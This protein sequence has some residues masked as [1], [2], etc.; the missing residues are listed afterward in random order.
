MLRSNQDSLFK[1]ATSKLPISQQKTK[2]QATR[3]VFW[4]FVVL[5]VSACVHQNSLSS[6]EVENAL[7]L[8]S[9]DQGAVMNAGVSDAEWLKRTNATELSRDRVEAEMVTGKHEKSEE[10]AR[11]LLARN[12]ASKEGLEAL[13]TSLYLQGRH[14][15][16]AY[17]AKLL[18][19]KY[20]NNTVALNISGLTLMKRG[21]DPQDLRQAKNLFESAFSDDIKEIAAGLNLGHLLLETGNSK[22][23]VSIFEQTASRCNDCLQAILGA[24]IAARRA[25]DFSTSK[26]YLDRAIQSKSPVAYY[27]LALWHIQSSNDLKSAREALG[28]VRFYAQ[29]PSSLIR[30]KADSFF[31]QVVVDMEKKGIINE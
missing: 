16:A 3:N 4:A 17:Y 29:D 10:S 24:S 7:V 25:K 1:E 21:N 30:Q 31:K 22:R 2:I 6:K 18:S 8:K 27:H 14:E 20:P 19:E 5:G 9:G 26:N 11:D 12:P 15:K 13:A 28:K 23:A